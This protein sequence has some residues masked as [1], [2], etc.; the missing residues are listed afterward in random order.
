[1]PST[2]F[3]Y[4]LSLDP[5]VIMEELYRRTDRYL[6]LEDNSYLATQIVMIISKPAESNKME[7]KKLS[8]PKEG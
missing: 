3:F 4:S 2:P 1:M 7:G 5:S 6:T 8:E